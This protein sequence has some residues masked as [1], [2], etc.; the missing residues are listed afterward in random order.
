MKSLNALVCSVN[1]TAGVVVVAGEG[2]VS[3][4]LLRVEVVMCGGELGVGE[5][6]RR[7]SSHDIALAADEGN[8]GSQL[9][10]RLPIV[11]GNAT[12]KNAIWSFKVL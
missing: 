4:V 3:V 12:T 6:S 9:G 1:A 2:R 7:S 8:V 10:W 11:G 5:G